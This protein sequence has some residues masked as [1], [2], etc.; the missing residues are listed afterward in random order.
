MIKIITNFFE[1]YRILNEKSKIIQHRGLRPQN[2]FMRK[3]IF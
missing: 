2:T 1:H 3:N